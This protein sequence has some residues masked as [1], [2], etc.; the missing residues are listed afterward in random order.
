M[1]LKR[2]TTETTWNFKAMAFTQ[3]LRQ[4]YQGPTCTE[5]AAASWRKEKLLISRVEMY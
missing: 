2:G 4:T 5:F 1:A 3:K